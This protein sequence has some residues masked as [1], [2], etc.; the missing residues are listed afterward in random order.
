MSAAGGSAEL[1]LFLESTRK[2]LERESSTSYLRELADRRTGFDRAWWN[3]GAGLGWLSLALPE[4]LGG[5]A[6]SEHAI[7]DQVLLA[8]EMGRVVAPGP[9]TMGMTVL[10]SLGEADDTA[11]YSSQLDTL[12]SGQE[13]ATLAMYEPGRPWSPFAATLRV[14]R[15][16]EGYRLTGIKDRIESGD[17]ADLFL[18]SADLHG[19]LAHF[20][21][22]TRAAGVRVEAMRSLDLT[23]R[24]AML[25]LEDVELPQA[26]RVHFKHGARVAIERQC[27]QLFVLQSAETAGV[28]ARVFELTL[29]W[30]FDRYSFGRQLASY[31]AIKHRCA[32]M[33]TWLEAM[34]AITAKAATAVEQ[35]ARDAAVLTRA[36]SRFVSTKSLEIIQ[37]CV[38]IHGGIGVTW[39][40]DLHIFLRRAI[41]NNAMY[42]TPDEQARDLRELLT[43]AEGEA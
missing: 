21:V 16:P 23:R 31:Q 34:H 11:R 17:Q 18:V 8:Q 35:G 4:A 36:A 22:P 10:S 24:F 14:S 33:R 25:T 43:N 28:T 38:Q 26:A 39:E 19:E 7:R 37:D 42:G 32:S 20:L 12:L 15:T 5:V 40:H 29:Q 9:L 30:A 6:L 2:F 41:V 3:E 13:V 27:Q 1:D